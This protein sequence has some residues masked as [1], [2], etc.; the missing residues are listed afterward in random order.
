MNSTPKQVNMS[1]ELQAG[2]ETEALIQYIF[3]N[4]DDELLDKIDLKRNHSQKDGVAS[5]AL[6]SAAVLSLSASALA[7]I[8]R[9]VEKWLENERQFAHLKIILQAK[10]ESDIDIAPIID[11]AKKHS[12]I[13]LETGFIELNTKNK[14]NK[15]YTWTSFFIIG[16]ILV[17]ISFVIY[18]INN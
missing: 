10:K 1:L 2:E 5:E 18:L 7:I 6:T 3:E 12:D 17:L 14:A 9:L 13:I 15:R 16:I 8:G 4:L 11:L